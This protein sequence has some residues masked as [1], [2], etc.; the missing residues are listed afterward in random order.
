M[1]T[2][3]SSPESS[4][5]VTREA[6][7]LLAKPVGY[8]TYRI[9]HTLASRF[10]FLILCVAI[11][12]SAL[13]Y[14]TVHAWALAVFFL[15]S[16]AVLILWL[17]DSLTLG[18]VRISRNM[19]QLA[20]VGMFVLGAVQ[21]LP[22]RDPGS[23]GTPSIPLIKSLS[24]DPYSTRLVLVEIAALLIYFAATFVFI[25]TPK[26]LRLLVRTLTIFGFFL[27]IFGLTQSFT[28]PNRVYWI[29]E[30]SQS[31]PFG[32]FINRHHFAGYMELALAVPLGLIF[33]G[34]V[35]KEKR[36]IYLFA[37]GLMGVA[38]IMTNSRGGIISLVAEILF[39]V[40][41]SGL[42]RRHKKRE[43]EEKRFRIKSAALKAGLA[44]AL[45]IALFGSVVLLG[46]EDVL[47]RLVGSV[48]TEDPT[49]GRAHFWAV[50]TEIIKAHPWL[51]T[52]L[53]AFAVVYTGY[54]SRN[55][56][57][58]LEQA[59]ND[60]LQVLSDGGI[61]GAVIGLFF[62]V[63]LFRMGFARRESGDDFRRGV[64]TGAMAGCFAVLV[65][66]FF[67]F[68][69][70]TPANALLFLILAALATMNG[71]VEEVHSRRKK[72]HRRE[73]SQ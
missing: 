18:S 23:I 16:V 40:A 60:Y 35:E 3:I 61:V 46:G 72:R 30:S 28:S 62:V 31:Q 29:R 66:S 11:I 71:R 10:A 65:H 41:V 73:S 51:G 38:L 59:H 26:R 15:G 24:F 69:L 55:G 45:V 42:R 2:S 22:L 9:R 47:S 52:G 50:T 56:L 20:L 68:T 6:E 44:L 14:G 8:V 7:A 54:D 19:L 64:A 58:R 34:S 63:N 25:D 27:A 70:H 43:S 1:T 39:L 17:V 67:D 36:L 57:Y 53:G 48:N 12:L 49:T 21:L 13:A 5:L 32:P 37:A 4:A 33:S